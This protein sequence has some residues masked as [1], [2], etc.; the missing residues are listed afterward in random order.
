MTVTRRGFIGAVGAFAGLAMTPAWWQFKTKRTI[1]LTP[2]CADYVSSRYSIHK[3][4]A[5]GGQVIG[6]DGM[7]L[8]RT[9]LATAP[10]LG[11]EAR[12]PDVAGLPYW[13]DQRSE[14]RPWPKARYIANGSWDYDCPMCLGKGGFGNVRKCPTCKGTGWREILNPK[15]FAD[16]GNG[17]YEQPCKRCKK[18]GWL[19]DTACDY[20][21]GEGTAIETLQEVGGIL[22]QG[23]YDAKLR[24]LGDLEYAVI[25]HEPVKFNDPL[26]VIAVRGDGFDGLVMEVSRD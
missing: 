7:A 2:F 24:A 18:L 25:R 6:T 10:E 13:T 20:C 17:S 21:K 8:I 1:D 9:A 5:Q 15:E 26:H 22:I 23:I 16:H 3:P 4:F 11:D 14:W 12:L 19:S